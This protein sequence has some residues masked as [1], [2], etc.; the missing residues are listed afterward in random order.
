MLDNDWPRRY[1]TEFAALRKGATENNSEGGYWLDG[2]YSTL[3]DRLGNL[4]F[5]INVSLHNP[6]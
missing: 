6:K 1:E 5:E 4:D 3:E 2:K